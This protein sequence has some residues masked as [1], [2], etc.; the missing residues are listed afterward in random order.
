MLKHTDL[1]SNTRVIP[2][3][4]PRQQPFTV[5]F[6]ARVNDEGNKLPF[7]NKTQYQITIFF[8]ILKHIVNPL[9]GSFYSI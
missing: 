2:P 9:S 6:T 5:E 8:H 3:T 4:D 1:T 7:S